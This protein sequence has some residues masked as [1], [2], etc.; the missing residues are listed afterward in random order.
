MPPAPAA[1][2]KNIK[3][4]AGTYDFF[5]DGHVM[6]VAVLWWNKQSAYT[7]T[8]INLQI[9]TDKKYFLCYHLCK[10]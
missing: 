5:L 3:N 1:A 6:G 2:A 10:L 8:I 7:T 4:A 9:L